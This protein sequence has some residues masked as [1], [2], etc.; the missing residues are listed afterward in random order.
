MVLFRLLLTGLLLFVV[1]QDGANAM[2]SV[3]VVY[4]DDYVTIRSGVLEVEK[5]PIHLGDA[6]SLLVEV[7]FDNNQVRIEKLDGELF[8]RNWAGQKGIELYAAPVVSTDGESHD[9]TIMRGLFRFQVLGC[10]KDLASCPG[11]KSYALPNFP[12]GYQIVDD[13]G[14]VLNNKSARFKPWP[15]VLNVTPALPV[16]GDGVQDFSSYFPGGAWPSVL[17]VDGHAS[18]GLWLALAGGLGL[19]IGF[20]FLPRRGRVPRRAAVYHGP[21]RRWEKALSALQ[22]GSLR[23]D[24]WAD[25]LRRC[26]TWYCLDELGRNPYAWLHDGRAPDDGDAAVTG[27]FRVFFMEVLNRESVQPGERESIMTEFREIAGMAGNTG[28]GGNTA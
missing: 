3:P 22:E 13:A 9:R 12:L 25:L 27:G 24:E 4:Q 11:P 15:G 2:Q 16:S 23:D 6:L 10:P 18:A 17:V 7:E 21:A 1:M 5:G 20:G 14:N 26:V 19:V 28:S 8:K